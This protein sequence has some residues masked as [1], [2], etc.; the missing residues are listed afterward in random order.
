VAPLQIILPLALLLA[1]T[2]AGMGYCFARVTGKPWLAPYTLYRN[3]MTMAPHFIW[4]QPR[5]QPL[6][7][8]REL[9]H[10]NAGLEM[11][12]Y[13]F[14]RRR[15]LRG[16]E[17]KFLDYWRFYLGPLLSIPLVA[18]P[19]LWRDR[20]ARL[21]LWLG[22]AFTLALVGQ[23][24]HNP[25]YAAPATGLIFL[26]VVMGMRRL[27]LWRPAGPWLVR[28]LPLACAALLV[29]NLAKAGPPSAG[30]QRA[31][32]LRQ[33]EATA[34]N[35]LVFM[36]Y[37]LYH[38]R[39]DE[40][41]YNGADIDG[42]RVV[43]ARELDRASN[44]KLMRY[45]AGRRVWLMDP[46]Q[47][48]P[49]P[50]PYAEAPYRPM[51]FVGLGAPGIE[52][53]RSPDRVRQAVLAKAQSA[54]YGCDGWSYYFTEA[55]GVESPDVSLGCYAGNDRGQLVTFDHWFAWLSRQR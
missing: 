28:G 54:L 49:R 55:T 10:F 34:G 27:R 21:P 9:R 35:H 33:L 50:I 47:P 2:V 26:I 39:G 11:N 12:H 31:R 6:Y 43:W 48:T 29:F 5:P 37:G 30:L 53:L 42:S 1:L 18:L 8:N 38:D 25:H 23:V 36:R 52:V 15:I 17:D 51:P 32:V 46:D 22:A 24:W 40:W 7:N 44:A 3:T 13:L 14:P 41:V 4:Q 20:K 45:F 19:W 16:L